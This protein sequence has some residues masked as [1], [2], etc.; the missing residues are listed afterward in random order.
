MERIYWMIYVCY[1]VHVFGVISLNFCLIHILARLRPLLRPMVCEEETA[2]G[3]FC[4]LQFDRIPIYPHIDI[5]KAQTEA[6]WSR[7]LLPL[8]PARKQVYMI[9]S[10]ESHIGVTLHD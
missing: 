9:H 10:L 4:R 7:V 1:L 5:V 2:F 8:G 6:D 3:L